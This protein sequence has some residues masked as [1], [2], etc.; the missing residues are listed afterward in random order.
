MTQASEYRQG[1]LQDA[2]GEAALYRLAEL[3]AQFGAEHIASTARGLAERVSEGRFYVACVGQFKRGKSTLLNALIG[4]TV[5]PTA[6]V[7][8]TAVPTIIRHGTR[9]AA[10]VRFQSDT[11]T[12]IAVSAVE[13]YVS[14]EKNP[15]NAKG[16]LGVEIFVPSALLEKGMCLVDTPGLGSVF[17]GN[18][19]ATQAFIPHIDVAVVVIGS[20]P[21]LSGDELQFLQAVSQEVHDLV[22]VLNK[23]DKVNATERTAALDFTRRVLATRLKRASPAIYEVSALDRLEQRGPERDWANL[24]QVLED[25]VLHSGRSL[26]HKATDRG[27]RRAARQL[28]A[29]IKEDRDALER[30]LEESE[31][32]IATVRKTLADSEAR[33]RDLGILLSAE[34][35]RLS[36]VFVERRNAFL[37]GAQ[38]AAR[39][40][41]TARLSALTRSH[42]GPAYRRSVNHAAQEITRAQLTPWFESEAKYADEEFRR[43][44]K[45][46]VEL[47]NEFLRH[48]GE[49]DLPGLEELPEDLS[50]DQR[51]SSRSQFRFH[52]IERVAAPASP[53]LFI[54]DLALGGMGIRGGIVR[55]AQE[56]L[57]QLLEVNASRVQSDVDERVHESRKRLEAEVKA[58]LREASAIADRALAR[59]RAAQAAG[60]PG[61]QE[62][63]AR[64]GGAEREIPGIIASLVL[65]P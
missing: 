14:E 43:T 47:A 7:P 25:L 64:L 63:L 57:D 16:V 39:S 45:R 48:L 44:A 60:A 22:F 11:W 46:F 9:P 2:P 52:V 51:L 8:V 59:A 42:N 56:F 54:S 50:V 26:V 65:S 33:A 13:E 32:R 4:H 28:L 24:T 38:A 27:I 29:V 15:E 49:S 20:D 18:T 61:V 21:P 34:Q 10:R 62:E 17:A 40:E 31:R 30:P 23:A 3:A 6:V 58:V 36:G 35:Q 19:A 1:V 37:N 5:L 53:L 55:D 41:L 12:D